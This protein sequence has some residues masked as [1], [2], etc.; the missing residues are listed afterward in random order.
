MDLS[1]FISRKEN[2]IQFPRKTTKQKFDDG[3]TPTHFNNGMDIVQTPNRA[4]YFT[5]PVLPSLADA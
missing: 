4:S 3:V 2:R 1:S 5:T